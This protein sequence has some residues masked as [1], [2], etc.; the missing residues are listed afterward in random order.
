MSGGVI[1]VDVGRG[2]DVTCRRSEFHGWR[3]VGRF[4][5]SCLYRSI[6]AGPLTC[7]GVDSAGE[8]ESATVKGRA[9]D[10]KHMAHRFALGCACAGSW[11]ACARG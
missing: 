9:V 3:G 6:A 10:S 5:A 2:T 1:E 4:N 8:T 11:F 7:R